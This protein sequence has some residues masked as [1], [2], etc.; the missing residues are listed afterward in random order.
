MWHHLGMTE[1][2]TLGPAS[3]DDLA[4]LLELTQD[5]ET[6]GSSPGL[7]GLTCDT[8]S[9]DGTRTVSSGRTAEY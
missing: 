9:G 7:A 2:V 3:E 8:G 5:P 6:A 4:V 1:R